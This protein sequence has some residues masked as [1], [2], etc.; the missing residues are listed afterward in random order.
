MLRRDD[1]EAERKITQFYPKKT[2]NARAPQFVSNN[3]SEGGIQDLI[4]AS[5]VPK[6]YDLPPQS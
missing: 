2:K 1:D 5:K 3:S 6:M 4:N